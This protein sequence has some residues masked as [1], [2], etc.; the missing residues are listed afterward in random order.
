MRRQRKVIGKGC[1]HSDTVG[2]TARRYSWLRSRSVMDRCLGIC[3]NATSYKTLLRICELSSKMSHLRIKTRLRFPSKLECIAVWD[4]NSIFE[5]PQHLK[6]IWDPWTLAPPCDSDVQLSATKCKP[7]KTREHQ[8]ERRAKLKVPHGVTMATPPAAWHNLAQ[9]WEDIKVVC[10]S[11]ALCHLNYYEQ[12]TWHL[13]L[14]RQLILS[15]EHCPVSLKNSPLFFFDKLYIYIYMRYEKG[16]SQ[17]PGTKLNFSMS[18]HTRCYGYQ[19]GTQRP[20][21]IRII[22]FY[23]NSDYFGISAEVQF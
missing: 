1:D 16:R 8:P 5:R 17:I 10:A 12:I 18:G 21:R 14:Y 7:I 20:F 13:L 9:Q 19:S 2:V 4:M 15:I 3:Q 22:Y 6:L 11:K 23:S